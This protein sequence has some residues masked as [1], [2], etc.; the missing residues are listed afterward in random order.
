VVAVRDRLGDHVYGT[1]GETLVGVVGRLLEERGWMLGVAESL[2]GGLLAKRITDV[3]GSSRFFAGGLAAYSVELKR[4]VLGVPADVLDSCG[5]VSAETARAMALGAR[6]VLG[7]EVVAATTGIAGPAGG[8]TEKPVGL[9]YLAVAWPGGLRVLRQLFTGNR[10]VIRSWTAATALD[11][12]R[13]ALA[14]LPPLGQPVDDADGG[15]R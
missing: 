12:V 2:S 14:G 10:V 1:G 15:C 11:E 4:N 5:P 7:A 6:E 3:P 13:R 9:V 8:T